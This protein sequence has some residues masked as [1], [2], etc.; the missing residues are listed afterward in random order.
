MLDFLKSWKTTLA[1]IA[2]VVG[3][4]SAYANGSTDLAGMVVAIITGIGLI[5]AKDANKTGTTN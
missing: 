5:L 1:G 4:V 2:S 3:A